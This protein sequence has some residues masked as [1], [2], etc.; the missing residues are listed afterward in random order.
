MLPVTTGLATLST[1]CEFVIVNVWPGYCAL[2]TSPPPPFAWL[3]RTTIESSVRLFDDWIAPPPLS[4]T[5]R[6]PRA[7]VSPEIVT[8]KSL[9]PVNAGQAGA[10]FSTIVKM[11][12][13]RFPSIV[14]TPAPGPTIVNGPSIRICPDVSVIVPV[15]F[16]A[17]AIAF[18]PGAAL[19]RL[20]ASR[21]LPAPES[22]PF[23]TVKTNGAPATVTVD[24]VG[25]Y[26]GA[27]ALTVVLPTRMP[28]TVPLPVV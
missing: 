15:T 5:L 19:A 21:R 25:A 18:G 11:R 22:A 12:S 14:S 2:K 23:V 9:G 17:K 1:N 4:A 13:F 3:L 24:C 20:I 10:L 27:C 6:L 28:F 7:S 16:A 26:P 8:G